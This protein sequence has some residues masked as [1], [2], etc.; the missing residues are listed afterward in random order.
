MLV[1]LYDALVLVVALY[2]QL[3]DLFLA[4]HL[5]EFD[6]LFFFCHLR[7][8]VVADEGQRNTFVAVPS[9]PTHSMNVAD[10]GHVF[11]LCWLVVVD[12]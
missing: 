1:F 7:E 8:D 6:L 11:V 10:R 3:Y 5:V 9:R 2:G 4:L 12:D